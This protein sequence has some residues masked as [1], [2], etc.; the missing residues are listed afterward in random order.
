M[1][2]RRTI[3]NALLVTLLAIG[4]NAV[5][6]RAAQSAQVSVSGGVTLNNI[7]R[8]LLF[9]WNSQLSVSG[10]GW[11]AGENVSISLH[12]PLNSLGVTA[13]DLPLGVL[14]ADRK[15]NFAGALT[16]PFD[17][18]I[19]GPSVRIP[20]PGH[21]EVRATG[22]V[23]GTALASD[24]IDLCPSTSLVAGSIDWGRERGG[25]DGVLPGFLHD[26][27]PERTDPE[28]TAVWDEIPVAVTG[29]IAQ[30]AEGGDEQPAQITP[31]D[32][33]DRHYAHDA[34]FFLQPDPQFRWITGTSNY[35]QNLPDQ[36]AVE[37]GRLEIEW[38]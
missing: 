22:G 1:L 25:R 33:P 11:Q 6:G 18:G 37:L 24:Q 14:T 17:G 27:S 10:R 26:F 28:W 19:S 23:S 34:N 29:T 9:I 32:Q 30:S 4:I 12:G 8:P 5:Q 36:A 38:E 20:R 3:Q 2:S 31:R 15:G 16:I 35:F 7:L 21:Y 13:A